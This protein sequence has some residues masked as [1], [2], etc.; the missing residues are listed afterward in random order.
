MRGAA[1]MTRKGEISTARLRREWPHHVAISTR[2]AATRTT[3]WCTAF[4]DALSVAPRSF[5][6][7]RDDLDF[8]V[9]CF[10]KPEDAEALCRSFGGERADKLPGGTRR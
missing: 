5:H 8:V 3:T 1:A 6:M 10:G 4:A 2:C 9:F 7:R